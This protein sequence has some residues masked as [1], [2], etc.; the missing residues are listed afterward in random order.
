QRTGCE[1]ELVLSHIPRADHHDQV[2]GAFLTARRQ[3][4]VDLDARDFREKAASPVE[5]TLFDSFAAL[6]Q[7]RL[8]PGSNRAC[9]S[10]W[11]PP[12]W[13]AA[14]RQTST[15]GRSRAPRTRRRR[16]RGRR[17]FPPCEGRDEDEGRLV[18]R[19]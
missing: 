5:R 10:T 4:N 14:N 17:Y 1:G 18:G 8:Q 6:R 7:I 16:V 11:P 12:W 2:R 15:P 19:L 9:D 13:P 3:A